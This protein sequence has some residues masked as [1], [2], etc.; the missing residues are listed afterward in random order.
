[1]P[2]RK[3]ISNDLRETGVAAHQS[4]EGY[5]TICKHFGVHHSTMR[6]IIHKWKTFKIVSSLLRSGHHNNF[7]PRPECTPLEKLQNT[8]K[9][10]I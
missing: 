5:K 4:G 8:E 6:K 3:G 2:R 9:S 7:T 10:Y 1:M